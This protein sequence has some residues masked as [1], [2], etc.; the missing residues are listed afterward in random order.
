VRIQLDEAS[1]KRGHHY[2]IVASI[3]TRGASSELRSD[4]VSGTVAHEVG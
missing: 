4:S 2:L 3:T 1:Y